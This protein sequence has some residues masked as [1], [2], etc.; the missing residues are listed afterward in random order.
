MSRDR[1]EIYDDWFERQCELLY[2]ES[3]KIFDEDDPDK[4]LKLFDSAIKK[5]EK[6]VN[7]C[8][9]KDLEPGIYSKNAKY[10][11]NEL[12]DL[13]QDK[14]DYIKDEYQDDLEWWKEYQ[15]QKKEKA[16]RKK[17]AEKQQAEVES[18]K[19]LIV[20]D[21]KNHPTL[22]IVDIEKNH[23]DKKSLIRKAISQLEY[24][25]RIQKFKDNNR[26]VIRL[27][28]DYD[29]HPEDRYDRTLQTTE[30]TQTETTS[31]QITQPTPVIELQPDKP[32]ESFGKKVFKF[33]IGILIVWAICR[34]FI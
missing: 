14:S 21:L 15:Q 6:L 12:E 23:P 7:T 31:Q 10:A 3:D 5:A 25:K 28:S 32:K 18:V 1:Q 17:E 2:E 8:E 20:S 26:L 30:H 29:S 9:E 11:K 24:D 4:K 19:S 22:K 27:R 34:L 16:Q 13:K 33:I